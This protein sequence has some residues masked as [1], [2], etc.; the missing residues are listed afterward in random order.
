V[1][2][3]VSSFLISLFN[4]PE[5]ARKLTDKEWQ[6]LIFV[7]RHE[8]LLARFAYILKDAGV[9]ETL[10]DYPK[11]H[12]NNAII[13]YERQAEQVFREANHLNAQ[14]KKYSKHMIFLKGAG[15]T[16]SRHP[17]GRGRVYGDID[18]LVEKSGLNTIEKHLCMRDWISEPVNEYDDRYYRQWA[19]EIP[20]LRNSSRGTILDIHHNIIPIISGKAPNV[21][22]LLEHVVLTEDG[23]QVLSPAALTMHSA[24]HLFFNE[25]FKHGFR[26]ILD[27]H[28]LISH[29]GNSGFWKELLDVASKT[30]FMRE[31]ALACHFSEMIWQSKIPVEVKGELAHSGFKTNAYHNFIFKRVLMPKHPLANIQ[32][33]SLANF[34]GWIRGHSLKMPSH[35]LFYH[36]TVKSSRYLVERIF[37][38]HIFTPNDDVGR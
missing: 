14:L 26:D 34:L 27:L 16:L 2:N 13:L 25:D 15:Y 33:L 10:S 31:L 23:Y 11:R 9:F 1:F 17:V 36:F 24:I 37:G 20:P 35:I 3:Q 38:A 7:L 8:Q 30:G 22:L 28:I 18:I 12:F 5:L 4:R 21:E 32:W 29:S 6:P 19:H